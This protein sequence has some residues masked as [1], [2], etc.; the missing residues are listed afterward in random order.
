MVNISK[1]ANTVTT[2]RIRR[3]MWGSHILP[4]LTLSPP[5]HTEPDHHKETLMPWIPLLTKEEH[6]GGMWRMNPLLKTSNSQEQKTCKEGN[7]CHSN[8]ERGTSKDKGKGETKGKCSAIT[9]N[10]TVTLADTA[11]RR[12]GTS[13]SKPA[14]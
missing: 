10:S 11:L 1:Y 8:P 4:H 3:K 5:S 6:R 7:V 2:G 12:K 13:T 9:V 14:E